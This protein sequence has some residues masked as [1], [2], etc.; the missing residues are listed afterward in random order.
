MKTINQQQVIDQINALPRS[1][2]KAIVEARV[3]VG[4]D[5]DPIRYVVIQPIEVIT[6]ITSSDI[7]GTTSSDGS[8]RRFYFTALYDA[9]AQVPDSERLAAT[10]D[11]SDADEA[12]NF[13]V[14]RATAINNFFKTL[15]K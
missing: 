8:H 13:I 14:T 1:A 15:I 12:Y 3:R 11:F 9:H 10:R 5:D 4:N 6:G 2:N 7:T